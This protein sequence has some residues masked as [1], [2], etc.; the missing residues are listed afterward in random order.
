MIALF[1]S[2]TGLD[3]SH[4]SISDAD[5]L[6]IVP[7]LPPQLLSIDLS[8]NPLSS[9][10]LCNLLPSAPLLQ[11][12][13]FIGCRFLPSSSST[14]ADVIRRHPSLT[15]ISLQVDGSASAVRLLQV[16]CNRSE[17][18][19]IH[20]QAPYTAA[21]QHVLSFT[22]PDILNIESI[23][24]INVPIHISWAQS[25]LRSIANRD[26]SNHAPDPTSSSTS[27]DALPSPKSCCAGLRS[28]RL[29]N[30]GTQPS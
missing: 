29:V 6:L 21:C 10:P 11:T 5:L 26:N 14:L 13:K 17:M 28:L 12:L 22:F 27:S 16:A 25:L 3:L 2:V 24:V 18:V 20:I 7:S 15:S 8:H 30:N 1:S 4:S 19:N 9:P 23:A